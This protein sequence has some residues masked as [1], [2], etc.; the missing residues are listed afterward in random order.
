VVLVVP[1]RAPKTLDLGRVAKGTLSERPNMRGTIGI[2]RLGLVL[3]VGM[4]VVSLGVDKGR[5]GGGVVEVEPVEGEAEGPGA[6]NVCEGERRRRKPE[7]SGMEQVGEKG[8]ER[9]RRSKGRGDVLPIREAIR[10]VPM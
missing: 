4:G 8:G 1:I 5:G 2:A 9:N 10:G 6:D 3:D 7:I